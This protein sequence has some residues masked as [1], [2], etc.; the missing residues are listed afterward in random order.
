MTPSVPP[1]VL[2]FLRYGDAKASMSAGLVLLA[3]LLIAL[4]AKALLQSASPAP[5]QDAVR[6]L[7]ILAVP[8]FIVFVAIVVERFS[9]L[10]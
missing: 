3:V 2:D 10:S 5:R 9:D 6:L 1:P 4:T 8:L 7:N